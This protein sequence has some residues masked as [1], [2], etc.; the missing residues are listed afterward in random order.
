MKLT[1]LIINPDVKSGPRPKSVG[2][3]KKI[4]KKYLSLIVLFGMLAIPAISFGQVYSSTVSKVVNPVIKKYTPPVTTTA[5]AS[6][7]ASAL[8]KNSKY[9][10]LVALLQAKLTNLG[11]D[12]G[13][14]DGINGT[15]TVNALKEVQ[16]FFGMKPDGI[17]G[18]ESQKL[19]SILPLNSSLRTTDPVVAI[20]LK[21][22]V[23]AEFASSTKTTGS[24]SNTT[25]STKLATIP[26]T[27]KGISQVLSKSLSLSG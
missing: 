1:K 6:E 8:K 18:K 5:K 19:F 21:K 16:R 25:N 27:P 10:P 22:Y 12:P 9:D 17:Y 23:K 15:K 11:T 14:V 26:F 20:A 3:N 2:V 4:M 13:P 24:T 7:P